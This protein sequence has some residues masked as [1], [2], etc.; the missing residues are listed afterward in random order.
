VVGTVTEGGSP[1]NQMLRVT[2]VKTIEGSCP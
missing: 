1:G 2:S